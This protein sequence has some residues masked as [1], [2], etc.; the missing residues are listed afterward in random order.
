MQQVTFE[1]GS[2]AHFKTFTPGRLRFDNEG[3][4]VIGARGRQLKYKL[5]PARHTAKLPD[6][7]AEGLQ[8][9]SSDWNEANRLQRPEGDIRRM[10][11]VIE[12]KPCG[13]D[14][15]PISQ[16]F[17]IPLVD[18]LARAITLAFEKSA[19]QKKN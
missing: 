4:N 14:P 5:T 6:A 17:G 7:V 12:C 15:D 2:K 10:V 11:R 8:K 16:Q 3:G 9:A 1:L 13:P 18:A 19:Q